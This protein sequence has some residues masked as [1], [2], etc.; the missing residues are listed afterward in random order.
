M[1][2]QPGSFANEEANLT[3]LKKV[4]IQ[5]FS[6]ILCKYIV[7]VVV[8]VIQVARQMWVITNISKCFF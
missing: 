8:Q 2:G 1:I 4:I 7:A 3:E 6:Y 5:Y